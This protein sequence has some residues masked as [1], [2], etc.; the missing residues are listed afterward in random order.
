M[1]K[2]L[3]VVLALAAVTG[4]PA[5]MEGDRAFANGGRSFFGA[6]YTMSNAVDG[7]A[8]TVSILLGHSSLRV[9][10]KHYAPW[11]KQRQELLEAAV[12]KA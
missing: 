7:N 3:I 8:E 12:M 1:K 6:V 2:R 5:L 11:V 10:E 9:T 4:M